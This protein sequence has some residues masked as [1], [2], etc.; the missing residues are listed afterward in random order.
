MS[1]SVASFRLRPARSG[2]QDRL[3]VTAQCTKQSVAGPTLARRH[4]KFRCDFYSPAPMASDFRIPAVCPES[5]GQPPVFR[6]VKNDQSAVRTAVMSR[7]RWFE[8]G[9][10]CPLRNEYRLHAMHRFDAS[11]A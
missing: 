8:A 10:E 4:A 11:R 7:Y 5:L 6:T 3:R 1:S 9:E 2:S